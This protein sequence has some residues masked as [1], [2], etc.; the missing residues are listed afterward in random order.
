MRPIFLPVIY[1]TSQIV[2]KKC[3]I[4]LQYHNHK[5]IIFTAPIKENKTKWIQVP[6]ANETMIL[7]NYLRYDQEIYDF[8]KQRFELQY[9]AI[10]YPR[11]LVKNF[12]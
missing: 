6:N 7:Q 2:I 4:P 8:V 9:R 11:K 5:Y 10:K 3:Q 12:A 1:P